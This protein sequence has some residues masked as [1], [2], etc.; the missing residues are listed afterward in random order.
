MTARIGL[1]ERNKR[2]KLRRIKAA[3]YELFSEKGFDAAT[4][5]EL[6]K[7][8]RVGFGTCF[9]YA[10]DKRDMLFL[11]FTEE[12][13]EIN[14]QPFASIDRTQPLIE[15]LIFVF[16]PNYELFAQ[17]P[18][19]SRL[20]L[21]EWTFALA[22]ETERRSLPDRRAY[23]EHLAQLIAHAQTDG[24]VEPS[25]SSELIAEM[26]Y[27]TYTGAVRQWLRAAHPTAANGIASLRAMLALQISGI[28]RR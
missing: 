21:R 14:E 19:L 10:H 2:E 25:A 27:A 24:Y 7:R 8:A 5:S 13:T 3:A 6:A 17:N 18:P 1:R 23:V 9:A 11:L 26:L 22:G 28:A 16:G 20:L 15:Q 12:L 4:V